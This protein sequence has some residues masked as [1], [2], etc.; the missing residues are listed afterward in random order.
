MSLRIG[1]VPYLN[2]KPLVDWFHTSECP[3]AVE[4]VYAVP[5]QLAVMLREGDLDVANV[6][7]FEG[8]QNPDLTLIPDISISAYGAVKSVRLFAKTPL[9]SIRSVALDR[10]SLT[11]A[12]L[13][14]ILLAEQF[15]L[16]PCYTDYP[17]DL[18]AMLA[19]CDAGLLIGDLK[20]FDGLPGITVY[21]LGEGWQE[22]TGLPFVYAGWLARSGS[23]SNEMS[24][25]LAEAKAWGVS[26]LEEIAATWA[27]R[28]ELPLERCRDYLIYVMNYNLTPEQLLGLET[29]RQKCLEQ[30]LIR[31]QTPL[32]LFVSGAA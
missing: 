12:A 6:S 20:L 8:F 24:D 9:A 29:F 2:A 26:R 11:S 7:I 19:N 10:S 30:G 3:A 16:N 17:P 1:S 5:S 18:D 14:R 13:T 25:L 23:A 22:L 32:P 27:A 31:L 21:D 15:G 28:M 4:V